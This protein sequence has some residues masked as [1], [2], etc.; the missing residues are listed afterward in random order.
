MSQNEMTLS[1]IARKPI[2]IPAGVKVEIVGQTISVKGPKGLVSQ[3]INESVEVKN[4]GNELLISSK[5][6]VRKNERA[7]QKKFRRA[8]AGTM[9]AI[10]N[11]M[12]E[13]VSNGFER[14]L[15]LVGVGYRAQMQGKKLNLSLGF[16]HPVAFDVPEGIVTETPTQTEIVIKGADR[17]LVGQFAASIRAIRTVEPYKG[18][19]VR[20][21][22]E[23]VVL[24]ETKK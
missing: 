14:R 18:K 1:R 16:S 13:G 17:Q 15:L 4:V 12:I 10:I 11:N 22:D 7:G 21:S 9:R 2:I 19:G 20:Y 8:I 3:Q 6:G 5:D 24:K 23:I